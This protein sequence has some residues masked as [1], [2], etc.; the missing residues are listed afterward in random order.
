MFQFALFFVLLCICLA[1]LYYGKFTSAVFDLLLM[2]LWYYKRKYPENSFLLFL[3]RNTT[4]VPVRG[5]RHSRYIAA[6]VIHHVTYITVLFIVLAVLFYFNPQ[7]FSKYSTLTDKII[8]GA[9][10]MI[11]VFF[12]LQLILLIVNLLKYIYIRI[13]AKDFIY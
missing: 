7:L 6:L 13:F 3:F 2:V 9:V 10:I 1:S 12:L 8:L 5:M 4:P 11:S